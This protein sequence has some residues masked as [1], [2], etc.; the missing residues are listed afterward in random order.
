MV[1]NANEGQTGKCYRQ[2]R[3]EIIFRKNLLL[4]LHLRDITQTSRVVFT[5][6]YLSLW[7]LNKHWRLVFI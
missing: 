4:T 2:W 5:R 3:Y 7:P 6:I 1:E